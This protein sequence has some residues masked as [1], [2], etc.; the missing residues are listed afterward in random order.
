M[1]PTE[2]LRAARA[3]FGLRRGHVRV[4]STQ[5]DKVCLAHRSM[6]RRRTQLRLVRAHA[7]TVSRLTAET[8]WLL[9]LSQQHGLRVPTP[10]V[11]RDGGFVSPPLVGR[12]A[13]VWHAVACSWVAGPHVVSGLRT[14]HMSGAGEFLG[15]MHRANSDAPP[16]IAEARPGGFH[17]CSSWRPRCA[18]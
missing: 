13:Q 9:H 18:M 8:L 11:W 15:R 5:F 12:D 17:A 1:L 6:D 3:G 7:D 10:I 16:G 4:L 14:A 2:I